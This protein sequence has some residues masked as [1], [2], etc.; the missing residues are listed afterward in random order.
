VNNGNDLILAWDIVVETKDNMYNAIVDA[1]TGSVVELIDWVSDA[2]YNV[3]PLGINDPHSGDRVTIRDPA[4]IPASPLGWHAQATDNKFTSTIGNNVY[5]QENLDG[6]A[7]YLENYRPNGGDDL[8]FDHSM[9]LG[10]EPVEYLDAAI[11]NLFYWN[12]IIH[13][14]FYMYG[15]DETAGNFQENNFGLGGRQGDAVYAQ[16]QDGS[17]VNNANF[18][19]P[20]DGMKGR[21]RMYIWTRTN[22][23]RDGDLDG[24]IVMHE[25]LHGIS[26]RLTGGPSNVGCLS[27]GE[28]G[29]MGEGWGDTFATITRVTSN[30]TRAD[31]YQMGDYSNGGNGI[32]KF[33]YATNMSVN[34][35]TYSFIVLPDYGGVHAK[36]EVWCVI[37]YEVFWNLVEKHGF[38]PDWF[39]VDPN[40]V[41]TEGTYKSII[42]G[43]VL[44]R[45][46]RKA[47]LGG[48]NIM[49]QLLVDG[50]KIQPCRPTFVDAR[51]AI[52][53]ADQINNN[54]DNL[55]ELW[56]GFAKRG[57]GTMARSPGI[58]SFSVPPQCEL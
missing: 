10:L 34:P 44:P 23:A 22:P 39:N 16:A 6:G 42:N 54:G 55:C 12:N 20:P 43:Q 19:T 18:A 15:F 4:Y 28:S 8:D 37:L 14:L 51:D 29:G 30:S 35:S 45:P 13:D 36:G 52:I 26:I 41:H 46:P 56:R 57:L 3:Y 32:R 21:M 9:D 25:Y 53:Q 27:G 5:A 2:S 49:F 38:D 11:T 48:N 58:E 40:N 31:V 47:A 33:P 1:M 50:M 17:G 24:G 7:E